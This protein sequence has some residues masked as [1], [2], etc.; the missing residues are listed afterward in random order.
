MLPKKIRF[1]LYV[2]KAYNF[3]QKIKVIY[4]TSAVWLLIVASIIVWIAFDKTSGK[5]VN[6]PLPRE[7]NKASTPIEILLFNDENTIKDLP[8]EINTKNDVDSLIQASQNSDLNID[9]DLDQ[10]QF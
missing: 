4:L 3:A 5:P 8:K 9:N 10:I 1:W 2:L 7:N 6:S